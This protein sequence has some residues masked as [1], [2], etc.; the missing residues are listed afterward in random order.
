MRSSFLKKGVD[1][2][3]KEHII[4]IFPTGM[5]KNKGKISFEANMNIFAYGKSSDIQKK[6]YTELERLL[7]E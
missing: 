7:V 2:Y 4:K 5:W 6:S 3:C 1:D